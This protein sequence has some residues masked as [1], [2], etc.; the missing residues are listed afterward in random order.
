MK[1]NHEN[2]CST[3]FFL[4]EKEIR[5]N[6]VSRFP[7]MSKVF[8]IMKPLSNKYKNIQRYSLLYESL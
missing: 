4:M 3:K 2:Q 1:E 8:Y 6:L 5:K 7:T